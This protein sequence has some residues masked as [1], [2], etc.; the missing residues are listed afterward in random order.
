MATDRGFGHSVFLGEGAASGATP[1]RAPAVL[2]VLLWLAAGLSVGY[3]VLQALGRAPLTPLAATASL[4]EA[5]DAAA[6]ARV[7]GAAPQAVAATGPV[8]A[9]TLSSRYQLI[10]VVADGADGGAALIAIDGQ[11]PRPYRVGAR[12]E[13]DVVLQ[14]VQRRAVRLAPAGTSA[15]SGQA[16]ELSLPEPPTPAS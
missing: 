10:G 7:L 9:P 1:R 8:A 5:P 11:P 16:F 12:L 2:A 14:A 15:G 13:G 4:P 3:W 6:L